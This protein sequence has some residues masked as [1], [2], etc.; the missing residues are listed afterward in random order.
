MSSFILQNIIIM[1]PLFKSY[2][3]TNSKQILISIRSQLI[4]KESENLESDETIYNYDI[5]TNAI[6]GNP[7]VIVAERITGFKGIV[8]VETIQSKSR[9]NWTKNLIFIRERMSKSTAVQ[10]TERNENE[11]RKKHN[12]SDLELLEEVFEEWRNLMSSLLVEIMKIPDSS[13]KIVDSFKVTNSA[14]VWKT[15]DSAQL[16]YFP[17]QYVPHDFLQS[18]TEIYLKYFH[19]DSLVIINIPEDL[20]KLVMSA[21]INHTNTVNKTS[22]ERDQMSMSNPIQQ[23]YG[24]WGPLRIAGNTQ[25][26]AKS[27]LH[28][29]PAVI[30]LAAATASTADRL[31][32]GPLYEDKKNKFPM[33]NSGL[34]LNEEIVIGTRNEEEIVAVARLPES[35]KLLKVSVF[36]E[37]KDYLMRT[38]FNEMF[39]RFLQTEEGQMHIVEFQHK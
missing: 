35:R 27:P 31:N 4:L 26:F 22:D 36:N 9:S 32:A 28:G 19:P 11:A 3:S 38:V 21:F 18:F 14:F 6:T 33:N 25:S 1:Y 7:T 30:S 15:I 39:Q 29:S 5:E 8:N 10:L 12:F 20:R 17:D 34:S 24:V 16:S 2:F 23:V 13:V 37:V